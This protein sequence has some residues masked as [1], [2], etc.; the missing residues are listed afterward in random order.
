MNDVQKM[1]FK[2]SFQSNTLDFKEFLKEQKIVLNLDNYKS[3]LDDVLKIIY[4]ARSEMYLDDLERLYP[5]QKLIFNDIYREVYGQVLV[6]SK[7]R[8]MPKE[9]F[10]NLKNYY[11]KFNSLAQA[12]ALRVNLVGDIE[13]EKVKKIK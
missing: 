13:D 6:N 5:Y 2:N 4:E 10:E 3:F 1:I 7:V 8:Q 11:K 12:G 9:L